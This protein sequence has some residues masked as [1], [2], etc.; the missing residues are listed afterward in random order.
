MEDVDPDSKQ[1]FLEDGAVLP[2][3][4][5]I[6]GTGSQTSYFGHNDWQEW[7]PGSKSVEEA[8]TIRHKVLYAFEVAERIADLRVDFWLLSDAR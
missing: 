7:A 1:V 8:T 6:V 2:Y 3:D 4:S 5:L